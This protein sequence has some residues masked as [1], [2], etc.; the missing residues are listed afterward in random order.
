[1]L[2]PAEAGGDFEFF[3]NL[4]T[5]GKDAVVA[6]LTGSRS[7]VIRLDNDPGTLSLFRG[8]HSMHRVTPVEGDTIRI[9]AVLAYA[10]E[11]G[12][13]LNELTQKLFYGRTA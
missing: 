12:R 7:G 4:R 8:H 10:E 3:P 6:R 5:A 11:P 2:Q 1:M 9:N 13:R